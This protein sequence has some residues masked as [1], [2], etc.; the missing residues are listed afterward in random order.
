MGHSSRRRYDDDEYRTNKRRDYENRYGKKCRGFYPKHEKE[1]SLRSADST[2]Y[3]FGFYKSTKMKKRRRSNENRS[4]FSTH[5]ADHYE[6]KFKE[7]EKNRKDSKLK[8]TEVV[9]LSSDDENKN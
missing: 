1:V 3:N 9:D 7:N 6:M 4:L 8:I 2:I 5:A